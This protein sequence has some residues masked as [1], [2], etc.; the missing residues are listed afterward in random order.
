MTFVYK[1]LTLEGDAISSTSGAQIPQGLPTDHSCWFNIRSAWSDSMVRHDPILVSRTRGERVSIEK[2]GVSAILD[3]FIADNGRIPYA[4]ILSRKLKKEFS[5]QRLFNLLGQAEIPSDVKIEATNILSG[6]ADSRKP[7]SLSVAVIP[8]MPSLENVNFELL[9]GIAS[10]E[11]TQ[12]T[13][14]LLYH[15]EGVIR[16]FKARDR[17]KDEAV[18]TLIPYLEPY[19]LLVCYL[20]G[21]FVESEVEKGLALSIVESLEAIATGMVDKL[22]TSLITF[23]IPM[24][25]KWLRDTVASIMSLIPYELMSTITVNFS[26]DSR[27][28]SGDMLYRVCCPDLVITDNRCVIPLDIHKKITKNDLTKALEPMVAITGDKNPKVAVDL[29]NTV[30]NNQPV[31]KIFIL[32]TVLGALAGIVY[33]FRKRIGQ[34]AIDMMNSLCDLFHIDKMWKDVLDTNLY[35]EEGV[36][37][38]NITGFLQKNNASREIIGQIKDPLYLDSVVSVGGF[39]YILCDIVKT[40]TG[41]IG[42]LA[43]LN[44]I[45]DCLWIVQ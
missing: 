38:D 25:D 12:K 34:S 43:P 23:Q 29:D 26:G 8:P 41:D 36:P 32:V 45:G 4:S 16:Y 19:L 14:R 1:N 30:K 33:L 10:S 40:P 31:K 42:R 24:E 21:I 6:R 7:G 27:Y 39:Y 22:P 28:F 35:C 3:R 11:A 18:K 13:I 20:N 44:H 9:R 17:V 37:A 5:Y 15:Q 2:P